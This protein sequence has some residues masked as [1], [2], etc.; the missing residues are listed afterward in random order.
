MVKGFMME[1]AYTYHHDRKS[2]PICEG[3]GWIKDVH[4]ISLVGEEESRTVEVYHLC[5]C[6]WDEEE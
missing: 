1:G 5:L 6:Q 3:S 2:C 4:E